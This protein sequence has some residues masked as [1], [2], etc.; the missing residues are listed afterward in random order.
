MAAIPHKL[1]VLAAVLFSGLIAAPIARGDVY[2]GNQGAG[3]VG[4]AN[5]DG[6]GVNQSFIASTADGV[7][8][9]GTHIYWTNPA[10]CTIGR[11]NR[12]G[13]GVDNNFITGLTD[14]CPVL[15]A[16]DG[17]HIYWAGNNNLGN[18]EVGRANLDG[19]GVNQTLISNSTQIFGVAV[20]GSHVYWTDFVDGT[21]GRASL[22][23]SS[24]NQTFITGA[25]SP[26]GV[27]VNG[28]NVFWANNGTGNIGRANLNGSG[29]SQSFITGGSGLYGVAVDGAHVYWANSTSNKIGRANLDGT[30]V[31]QS[32]ITGANQPGGIA[33][34]ADLTATQTSTAVSCVPGQAAVGQATTCTAKVVDNPVGGADPSGS[35]TFSSDSSGMF[36]SGGSCTLGPT[37]NPGESSCRVGYT[38]TAVGSG[39]HAITASYNADNTHAASSGSATVTVTGGGGGGGGPFTLTVHKSGTGGGTVISTPAG[40][41]CGA[42]CAN[43]FAAGASVTLQVAANAGSSFV[44]FSGDCSGLTCTVQ[45]TANRSVTVTF[46]GPPSPIPTPSSAPPLN[47]QLPSI[48]PSQSCQFFGRSFCRTVP[49]QYSCDPG[50]WTHI[51]PATPYQF[52]WQ[53]LYDIRQGP[54]LVPAGWQREP[55]GT[56]QIFD[57]VT[58]LAVYIPT[59]FFRCQVT[60]TGPGG[61]SV[62][63]SPATPLQVGPALPNGV[64]LF[65]PTPVDIRVT[66]IEV[67]QG[68]QE[69]PCGGC[70]FSD[71]NH[72]PCA[73]CAAGTLPSRDQLHER[74][75]GDAD[76]SGVTMSAGKDTIVR[77]YANFTSG[78]SSSLVGATATLEVLDSA[79]NRILPPPGSKQAFN[80]DVNQL[81]TPGALQNPSAACPLCVDLATRANPR[82]SFYFRIPAQYTYHR[83][84]SFRAT[85]NPP[86]GPSLGGQCSGCQANTFTLNSVPF[87]QAAT[88]E[89]WPI[90][91]T[92]GGVPVP[93]D[94]QQWLQPTFG[95]AQTVMPN[96]LKIDLWD[97]TLAV[98]GLAKSDAVEA[99]DDR[100]E[101]N[102]LPSNIM[103]IGVY[104]PGAYPGL[105]INTSQETGTL[106]DDDDPPRAIVPYC[107]TIAP[108][109]VVA[110]QAICRPLTAVAHEIT[111]ALAIGHADLPTRAPGDNTPDCGGDSGGSDSDAHYG[112]A[113][114]PDYEGRIQG[115]GLDRR[116]WTSLS[117]GAVPKTFVEGFD[118]KG[119]PAAGTQYYDYMSY[120]PPGGVIV[121]PG[122]NPPE[123]NDW[124]SPHNW[125][126]L[127]DYH[128]PPQT[129][130]AAADPHARPGD[131]TPLRVIAA[132]DGDGR[133]SIFDVTPG[134]RSTRLPTPGSPYRIELH[135]AAGNVLADVVPSTTPIHAD[136]EPPGVLLSGTLPLAPGAT[137]VAITL[138]GQVLA[139]QI[140]SAHAPTA[141]LLSP[142]PGSRV[143]RT[144]TS[145]VRFRASD[146]D[147]DPLSAKVYYSPD[148]G[149]SW[150]V[151]A[152][153]LTGNVARIPSRL[154]ARSAHGRLQV[155]ISD[156]FNLTTAT[157][158]RLRVAG[159]PPLVQITG[160]PRR[161]HVLETDTLPLRGSAFDDTGR[162]LTGPHLTWY[163][164]KRRIGR[165]ELSSV[166][167]LKPGNITI[168]LLATDSH[169]RSAQAVLHLHVTAV[170]ARYLLFDAPILVSPKARRVAIRVASSA[171]ATFTIAGKS[172]AVGQSARTITFVVR[173][174]KSLIRLR[175]TLRS[176]GGVIRGTYVALRARR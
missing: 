105:S 72:S 138:D 121:S 79:G 33:V 16:V 27:A 165:G 89:I 93:P 70:V 132:V 130:P 67:T 56:S 141:R 124:I 46:T 101:D 129:L 139:R 43:S 58:H 52:E 5:P 77:V 163:L 162:P 140:R 24:P 174:G 53:Q 25:S 143:G 71:P 127:L 92:V 160:A 41:L 128:S 66:G 99:V 151:V 65:K 97:G 169:G 83:T 107:T 51:D 74:A 31:N 116:Y 73:T 40:I 90:P 61:T 4:R 175:C 22:D 153:P 136:D 161:G 68:T 120:C 47:I 108:P 98:D 84:L 15:L 48:A 63:D 100:A 18:G 2:W 29:P 156:G 118:H 170:R 88:V 6:T 173:R 20:D 86:V 50:A 13:S 39:A 32:F 69:A 112:E 17:S 176:R 117:A 95:D 85:V 134:R 62:A 10:P 148:G 166:Q 144:P 115:V 171:P 158:G 149:R 12:D 102:N 119:N 104:V 3:S 75:P 123:P 96:P 133:A 81:I 168:R 28:A 11:A 172:Y 122:N 91:L 35:V 145:L 106:F 54:V 142:R 103:P 19:T 76:Y 60:A 154:L 82:S 57:A 135:D 157:S 59:G 94:R 147:G 146:T 8:I 126:R 80:P 87:K 152:G 109:P 38:P 37:G 9:D 164:G 14:S 21:I 1:G 150:K 36:D 34:D 26:V 42:V 110:N 159:S 55:N 131:G 64:P 125:Q 111:H 155:R 167:G 137:S 113:W 7:A 23:G 114:P 30:G 45:M 78:Q 49:Y 44:G